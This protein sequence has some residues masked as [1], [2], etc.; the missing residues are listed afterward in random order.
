MD[1]SSL[2]FPRRGVGE[3][4]VDRFPVAACASSDKNITAYRSVDMNRR[5][6]PH[7]LRFGGH[8][9]SLQCGLV[10]VVTLLMPH[11]SQS[12]VRTHDREL[13]IDLARPGFVR[14][15]V[16]SLL[17]PDDILRGIVHGGDRSHQSTAQSVVPT[18]FF[19][20]DFSPS[21]YPGWEGVEIYS[22]LLLPFA[23]FSGGG[24]VGCDVYGKDWLS[25]DLG[26]TWS[27]STF[28]GAISTV[29]TSPYG[30]DIVDFYNG[31]AKSV[32]G[33]IVWTAVASPPNHTEIWGAT[34]NSQ[35]DLF[36]GCDR[37][38]GAGLAGDG[39]FRSTDQG[40]TWSLV[41]SNGIYPFRLFPTKAGRTLFASSGIIG[42]TGYSMYMWVSHDDG[43]SWRK[44]EEF[45]VNPIVVDAKSFLFGGAFVQLEGGHG[46][47]AEDT[48][49][50][51]VDL[52]LS[53][54][55]DLVYDMGL[56]PDNSLCLAGSKRVSRSTD[57][58]HSWSPA[59]GSAG[60]S[61]LSKFLRIGTNTVLLTDTLG[62]VRTTDA[63]ATWE[64]TLAA[65]P[66]CPLSLTNTGSCVA[67]M[68]NGIYRS[69]DLGATWQRVLTRPDGDLQS[70]IDNG[71]GVLLA[72]TGSA[73]VF[74]S[75]DDGISWQPGDTKV[76][77]SSPSMLRAN[78]KGGI[79]WTDEGSLLLY[80]TDHGVT[81][82][83]RN[84]PVPTGVGRYNYWVDGN[85]VLYCVDY[86]YYRSFDDGQSWENFSPGQ[87]Y[88]VNGN[89]YTYATSQFLVDRNGEYYCS[90]LSPTADN[91]EVYRSSDGGQNFSRISDAIL[92]DSSGKA[93]DYL[94]GIALDSTGGLLVTAGT[95]IFKT[96]TG[97]KSWTELTNSGMAYWSDI[98]VTPQGTLFV[99]TSSGASRSTDDG[100]S[101]Q[102][103]LISSGPGYWQWQGTTVVCG[104]DEVVGGLGGD[105]YRLF[106]FSVPPAKAEQLITGVDTRSRSICFVDA[107]GYLFLIT[108]SAYTSSA[109]QQVMFRRNL[110]LT[111]IEEGTPKKLPPPNY[112][113]A[114]NYPNPFNPATTIRYALP[115]HSHVSLAVFN[116][117]GQKVADLLNSDID[118]GYHEVSFDGSKHASGV[119]FYRIQAGDFVQTRSLCLIR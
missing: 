64:R 59:T 50:S 108:D 88:L 27:P 119:Y 38:Q 34:F 85:D 36:V 22:H 105:Y 87:A 42:F 61:A 30:W 117:L 95:K 81:W 15:C 109:H 8:W 19:T 1:Q 72:G 35:G 65:F 52:E 96:T 4:R 53:V 118:A 67:I 37:L 20:T 14:N 94:G 80:S 62:V 63:G 116:T 46:F 115:K 60:C 93:Q 11:H 106:R 84:R 76:R 100:L 82:S 74:R 28:T 69:S 103:V 40:V 89:Q 12:Q 13:G 56:M 25:R 31:W 79:F 101:W 43:K 83:Q 77:V 3:W 23:S 2:G 104:P 24:V 55:A 7:I 51:F 6:S 29:L 110:P 113:L 86:E 18:S 48:N 73:G 10:M 49:S 90:A 17:H 47:Y 9:L 68:H 39:I 97:G 54:A 114:Q 112:H 70:Y 71:R 75:T 107:S 92:N 99:Q 91:W 21:P 102:Q 58:G 57:Q 66:M 44:R 111:T 78:K 5:S 33:G 16:E 41:A 26:V 45:G 98:S 32:D